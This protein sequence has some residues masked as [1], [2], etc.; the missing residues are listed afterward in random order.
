M[1]HAYFNTLRGFNRTLRLYLLCAALIGFTTSGGIYSVLLNLYLLR[2]D[3]SLAFIGLINAMGALSYALFGLPAGYLGRRWGSR[4]ATIVGLAFMLAGNLLLPLVEYTPAHWHDA[5]LLSAR[6]PRAFGFALYLVNANPFLMDVATPQERTHVF[7]VQAAL[8]PLAGFAGSLVAGFLPG[9]FADFSGLTERDPAP[10]RYTL[11]L[12]AAGLAPALLALLATPKTEGQPLPQETAKP[13]GPAPRRAPLVVAA[14]VTLLLTAGVGAVQSFFNLYLD[15]GLGTS[16]A[17]IGSLAAAG[18]LLGGMAALAT[19]LLS[20]RLGLVALISGGALATSIGLLPLAL[21]PHW[22]AAGLGFLAVSAMGTLRHAALM[23]FQQ[24]LVPRHWRPTMS[25]L[26][27]VA[28]GLSFAAIALGGGYLV[29]L[30]GYRSLFLLA[31]ALLV[32]GGLIFAAY[33]RRPRGEYKRTAT[34]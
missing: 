14:A 15:E 4:R 13:S 25:A 7:S 33:F 16:T 24:E 31:A 18:Q 27:A 32:L 30:L 22:G 19:P 26:H 1:L 29:P 21:V 8:W 10:F 23:V 12:G 20:A 11:L 9:F 6:L 3:Y 34:P 17:L 5:W 2:L 28:S